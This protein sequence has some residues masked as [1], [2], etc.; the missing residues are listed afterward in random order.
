MFVGSKTESMKSARDRE[1]KIQC[2][3]AKGGPVT[4]GE[5]SYHAISK[6]TFSAIEGI[7]SGDRSGPEQEVFAMGREGFSAAARVPISNWWHQSG[8]NTGHGKL[9]RDFLS[10]FTAEAEKR[11]KSTLPE[12]AAAAAASPTTTC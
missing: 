8:K 2:R 11:G 3:Q 12:P 6:N 5:E 9:K 10:G 4:L 7:P 1:Y